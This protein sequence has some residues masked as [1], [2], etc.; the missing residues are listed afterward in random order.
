MARREDFDGFGCALVGL[1][2][3][4]LYALRI[5]SSYF[6]RVGQTNP[7]RP[8]RSYCTPGDISA[9]GSRSTTSALQFGQQFS[10]LCVLPSGAIVSASAIE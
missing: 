4:A 7:Q 2:G 3:E 9:M 6:S 1:D 10:A 8:H 5:S